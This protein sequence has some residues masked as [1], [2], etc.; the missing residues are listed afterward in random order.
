M[1]RLE[2]MQDREENK[3]QKEIIDHRREEDENI[4]RL[5]SNF[6]LTHEAPSRCRH[7]WR[8][9]PVFAVYFL[10]EMDGFWP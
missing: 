2:R 8:F 6:G 1:A 4:R 10:L 9:N 5:E 3:G 7:L